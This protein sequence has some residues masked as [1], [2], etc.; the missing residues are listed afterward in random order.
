MGRMSNKQAR[1][2][3]RQLYADRIALMDALKSYRRVRAHAEIYLNAGDRKQRML[4]DLD[5]MIDVIVADVNHLD[6]TICE[7]RGDPRVADYR[8]QIVERAT[9]QGFK[10]L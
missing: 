2:R 1:Q 6:E 8:E 3:I 4:D 9:G 7:S 5:S 10:M